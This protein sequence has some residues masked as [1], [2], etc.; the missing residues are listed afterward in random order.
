MD[1]EIREIML[2]ITQLQA[3][4]TSLNTERIAKDLAQVRSENAELKKRLLEGKK[5]H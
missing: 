1:S 5:A 2:S 4:N 3:R